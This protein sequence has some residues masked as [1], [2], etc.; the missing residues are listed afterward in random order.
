[1]SRDSKSLVPP[2]PSPNSETSYI[3]CY[4]KLGINVWVPITI[5]TLYDIPTE[6]TGHLTY[7]F[8]IHTGFP[9]HPRLS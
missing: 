1:M 2:S 5:R 4:I 8:I 7:D 6:N 9:N 3:H